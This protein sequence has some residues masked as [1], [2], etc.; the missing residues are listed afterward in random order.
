MLLSP[1][2]LNTHAALVARVAQ[3]ALDVSLTALSARAHR[4]SLANV[5]NALFERQER[6]LG[7]LYAWRELEPRV[8]ATASSPAGETA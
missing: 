5:R 4:G 6:D 7:T 2:S 8:R 3:S 1:S